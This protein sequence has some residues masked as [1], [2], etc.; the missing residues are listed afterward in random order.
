[1]AG[2]RPVYSVAVNPSTNSELLDLLT[3]DRTM[4]NSYSEPEHMEMNIDD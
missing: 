2:N 1:M 4:G 3:Y